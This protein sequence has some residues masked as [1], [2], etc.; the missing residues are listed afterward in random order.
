MYIYV[1]YCLLF[2]NF[3]KNKALQRSFVQSIKSLDEETG[4]VSTL[5]DHNT[6][7]VRYDHDTVI[8]F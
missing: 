3:S 2:A 8:F 4:E 5:A 7:V 6:I 1:R